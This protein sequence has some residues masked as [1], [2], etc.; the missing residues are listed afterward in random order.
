[1]GLLILLFVL[2][3]SLLLNVELRLLSI[4]LSAFILFASIGAHNNL[5]FL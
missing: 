3:L 4:F 2:E 1:V 5:S